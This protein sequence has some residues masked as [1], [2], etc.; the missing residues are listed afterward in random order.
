MDLRVVA[1]TWYEAVMVN[2]YGAK[3]DGTYD[4]KRD[5][6]KAIKAANM[7]EKERGYEPSKYYIM[8][9]NCVRMFEDNGDTVSETITKVRVKN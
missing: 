5:V 2:S 8:L 7:R 4:N 3:L 1:S 9:C 6:Q